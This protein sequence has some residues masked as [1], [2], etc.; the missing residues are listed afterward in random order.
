[1]PRSE[2]ER[3][4][5]RRSSAFP[6]VKFDAERL[7]ITVA[8]AVIAAAAL[9]SGCGDPESESRIEELAAQTAELATAVGELQDLEAK[10]RG[11][12]CQCIK[13]NGVDVPPQFDC[14]ASSTSTEMGF[15]RLRPRMDGIAQKVHL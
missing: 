12:C 15:E 8:P 9:L 7:Q 13:V 14:L 3:A 10:R 1:M 6:M 5:R 11:K 4:K 2:A